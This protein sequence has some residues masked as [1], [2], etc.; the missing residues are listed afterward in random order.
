MGTATLLG[1]LAHEHPTGMDVPITNVGGKKRGKGSAWGGQVLE[2]K[3]ARQGPVRVAHTG[4]HI[5][6]AV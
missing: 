4:L 2:A 1:D 6:G 3:Q 5:H